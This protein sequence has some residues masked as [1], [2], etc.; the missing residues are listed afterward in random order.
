MDDTIQDSFRHTSA[1]RR[2]SELEQLYAEIARAQERF[3][4]A[5][6]SSGF[7]LSC[8]RGCGSCCD[9]FVPDVIPIEAELIAY[10]VLTH[11]IHVPTDAQ[12]CPFH[13]PSNAEGHC[14]I[15]PARPL[16]C[17]FFGFSAVRDRNGR[18]AFRLCRHMPAPQGLSSRMLDAE[19]LAATFDA[20]PP[21]MSDYALKV[22]AIDPARAGSRALLT[23]QLPDALQRIGTLLRFC[24]LST[25][26]DAA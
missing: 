14:R 7:S 3:L 13:D 25:E 2:L 1:G 4:E 16:I 21:V 12:Y 17:R 22:A 10:H 19:L 9:H 24:D 23:A 18:P 6:L 5:T 8:P 20:V 11:R 15:Y 26:P